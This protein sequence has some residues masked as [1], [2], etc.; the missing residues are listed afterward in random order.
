MVILPEW[1]DDLGSGGGLLVPR[2]LIVTTEGPE[3]ARTDW[4]SVIFWYLNG[5][6]ERCFE[7]QNGSIHS[8]SSHLKQWDSR[9]WDHAWV[10][11]I[12]LFLRRW[13]ARE[14]NRSEVD[15]FGP[16]PEANIVLTHDLDAIQKT[17]AIRFK[18]TIFILWNSLK[19]LLEKKFIESYQKAQQAL[20]FFFI[21]G[22]L[23]NWMRWR[24][25]KRCMGCAT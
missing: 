11:R 5:N 19:S 23:I 18:Q 1:S 10:N 20:R 16:L 13:A 22:T 7:E 24:D 6:A 15:V 12:A 14:L 25:S 3:W 17:M 21:L 9:I 4:L 2:S 8:Y